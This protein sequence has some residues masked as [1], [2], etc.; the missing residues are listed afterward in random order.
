VNKIKLLTCLLF[1]HIFMVSAVSA[2][3]VYHTL[4]FQL[5]PGQTTKFLEF[6]KINSVDTRNFDGCK[7]FAILAD[8]NDPEKVFF[9]EIWGSEDQHKA[10]QKFRADT[11]FG[12]K[13]QPFL[14]GP[15]ARNAYTLVQE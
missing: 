12:D 14:A 15:P 5:K 8:E 10:Y 3:D 6:M 11:K 1:A 7:H 2:A 9:Y 4:E 13:V